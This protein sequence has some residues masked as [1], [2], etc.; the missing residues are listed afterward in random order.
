MSSPYHNVYGQSADARFTERGFESVGD[1]YTYNNVWHGKN[2]KGVDQVVSVMGDGEGTASLGE[3]YQAYRSSRDSGNSVKAAME[4]A[5]TVRG[6]NTSRHSD[7][8]FV[9]QDTLEEWAK[10][11]YLANNSQKSVVKSSFGGMLKH[12]TG[13]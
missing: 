11:Y 13:Y 5:A 12:I 2:S 1:G 8:S 9:P 10:E 3:S 7:V 4:T 6:V